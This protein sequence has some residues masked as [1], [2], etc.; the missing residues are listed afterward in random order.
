MKVVKFGGTSLASSE[1]I[2]KAAS[3]VKSDVERRYVVVSAP[4]KRFSDDIKITD[5]LYSC[6]D[7][8][9]SHISYEDDL[10]FIQN[11]FQEIVD[12]LN[13]SVDIKHEFQIIKDTIKKNPSKDYLAS[14]GEYL[15]A[16]IIAQVLDFDFVDAF[17]GIFF[18]ENGH[19]D[20]KKTYPTLSQLLKNRKAVISGFYGCAYDGQVKTFSRGGSDVTGAIVARSVKAQ[21]YENWTDVDGFRV[22]DPRIVKGAKGIEQI[23]YKELRELSYMGASVLHED[24]VFP[25]RSQGI[26]L[27]IRNTN[28]PENAGTMITSETHA[29]ERIIAGIAG[30]KG[31]SNLQIEKAM[32]NMEIG[33]GAKV[34]DLIA[35]YGVPYEH[36]PTSIDTMSVIV[37][38]EDIE[39]VRKELLKDLDDLLRPDRVF[40]HDQIALL[41][42]VGEGL[43]QHQ[44]II[45]KIFSILY[46]RHIHLRMIDIGFNEM[47]VI[48]G[49]DEKEYE[50][51]MNAL[52]EGLKNDC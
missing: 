27:N 1:Q 34:L 21:L 41:A 45:G 39:K 14:R 17:D 10:L 15:N 28:H 51:A 6:Y 44:E 52:Y 30:K 36:T 26:P 13:V 37:E 48:L 12:E 5:L 8:A 4:G 38:T 9:I 32:M 19:L 49:I 47:T 11:R 33:F 7:K 20:E 43:K 42:V 35:K 31:L 50:N 22:A 18:D 46:E 40:I 25:I 23:S 24:A 29:S 2:R 3:I 16:K